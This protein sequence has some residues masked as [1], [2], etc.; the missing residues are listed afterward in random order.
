[1]LRTLARPFLLLLLP[2]NTCIIVG[3]HDDKVQAGGCRTTV[4]KLAD[5]L[6]ESGI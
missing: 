1:M 5:F 2:G 4:G 3:F 6:K